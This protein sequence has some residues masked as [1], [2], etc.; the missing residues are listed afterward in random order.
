MRIEKKDE[1]VINQML[2]ALNVDNEEDRKEKL[3][4]VLEE[5]KVAYYMNGYNQ[6]NRERYKLKKEQLELA[7]KSKNVIKF[8]PKR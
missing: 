3:R 5:V 8:K 6:A 1:Y 7:A 2:E 4:Q